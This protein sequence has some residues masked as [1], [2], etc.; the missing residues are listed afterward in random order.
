[1][2]PRTIAYI[3]C[4]CPHCGTITKI[5]AQVITDKF[6]SK[7][8]TCPGCEKELPDILDEAIKVAIKYQHAVS[9]LSGLSQNGV[10][11]FTFE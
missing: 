2:S 8:W 3:E 7:K 1:M 4:T 11:L 6:L 10:V 9:L 5:P